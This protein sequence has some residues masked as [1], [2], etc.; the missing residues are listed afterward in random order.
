MHKDTKEILQKID[1]LARHIGETKDQNKRIEEFLKEKFS[2]SKEENTSTEHTTSEETPEERFEE[3]KDLAALMYYRPDAKGGLNSAKFTDSPYEFTKEEM[4]PNEDGK[5]KSVDNADN[6]IDPVHIKDLIYAQ[7]SQEN[8]IAE[9]TADL[10]ILE[11]EKEKLE[12]KIAEKDDEIE[13][14][15][16]KLNEFGMADK[17]KVMEYLEKTGPFIDKERKAEEKD[18]KYEFRLFAPIASILEMYIKIKNQYRTLHTNDY[19]ISTLAHISC[20]ILEIYKNILNEKSVSELT[21]G[22]HI[23]TINSTIND[24]NKHFDGYKILPF[25]QDEENPERGAKEYNDSDKFLEEDT[26]WRSTELSSLPITNTA[27][28]EC[29]KKAINKEI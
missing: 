17:N 7:I 29:L 1:A 11:K 19:Q 23:T 18:T 20:L 2:A 8:K 3:N 14:M 22:E 21:K 13:Q 10:N 5:E 16:D 6:W 9:Q 27:G 28:D 24:I 25:I 12:D 4:I 15:T 26:F